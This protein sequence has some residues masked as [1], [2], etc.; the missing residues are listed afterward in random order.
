MI[1][2]AVVVPLLASL[3]GFLFAAIV[4][5]QW[6]RRRDLSGGGVFI[7][8]GIHKAHLLRYLAG[9]PVRIYAAALPQ[10]L[11]EHEGKF[12]AELRDLNT[13]AE[14]QRFC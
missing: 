5:D 12:Q 14:L 2:S 3:V 9:E 11:D 1:A 10:V 6:R 13:N 8:G 7:D 4:L